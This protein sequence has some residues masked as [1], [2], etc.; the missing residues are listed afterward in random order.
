MFPSHDPPDEDISK[1]TDEILR[2][3]IGRRI[4]E[5]LSDERIR[6]QIDCHIKSIGKAEIEKFITDNNYKEKVEQEAVK[7]FERKM[8]S[9]PDKLD[10]EIRVGNRW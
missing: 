1:I 9:L 3:Y 5:L 6:Y 10:V 7:A 4:S 8:K 2:K